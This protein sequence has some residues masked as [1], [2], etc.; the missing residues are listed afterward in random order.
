MSALVHDIDR[1]RLAAC[2][3]TLSDDGF[4]DALLSEPRFSERLND[5]VKC[6]YGLSDMDDDVDEADRMLMALSRAH[7]EKLAFR[8]GAVLHARQFLMEVRGPVLS[9]LAL[10]FGPSA[11]DDA[12]RHVSLAPEM[13]R[14]DDLD[15]L[16]ASVSRGGTACLAAWI[17]SLPAP[18]QRRIRL[19]WP[20]DQSVPKTDDVA[21]GDRGAVIL[22]SLVSCESPS[23]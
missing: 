17:A 22:K 14:I 4:S 19:K 7:L 23:E 11:M 5:I 12:R 16:E 6:H 9:A 8:A 2:F 1:E 10:R 18:V 13:A 20:N 21:I 15:T 3:R